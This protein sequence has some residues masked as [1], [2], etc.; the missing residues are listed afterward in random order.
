[1]KISEVS[2][3]D[4]AAN[5]KKFLIIKRASEEGKPP[6]VPKG[7]ENLNKS[8]MSK[9]KTFAK[10]LL[11]ASEDESTV[12]DFDTAMAIS[13]RQQEDWEKDSKIREGIWALRDS[14]DS[15]TD[16]D[17]VTDKQSPV[18]QSMNQ[19][20]NYLVENNVLKSGKKISADRMT[21][22]ADMHKKLGD[23]IA[24]AGDNKEED[25]IVAKDDK[26]FEGHPVGCMCGGCITKRDVVE[27]SAGV[28]DEIQ[29]RMD[30]LEKRNKDLEAEIKK[31]ANE[32]K[33]KEF[34]AKAA[35][36]SGLGIKADELGPVLKSMSEVNPEGYAKIEATLLAANEQ[37]LKGALFAETGTGGS[38]ETA[39]TKRVD[40]MAKDIQK[41]DNCTI[42]KARTLVYKENPTMYKE[43]LKEQG[44]N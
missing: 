43:Y 10:G 18:L 28:P 6:D 3:V 21:A 38:G 34:I 9:I 30:T 42:E 44:G 39:I 4:K 15:I 1:M 29:K 27:K 33:T 40:A 26:G 2:V 37:V 31:A 23:L 16:D 20:F 8:L 13:Q 35:G 5:G 41:R 22:L 24:G 17:T 32:T 19:F 11:T 7:G 12:I 14:I 36:F 25:G